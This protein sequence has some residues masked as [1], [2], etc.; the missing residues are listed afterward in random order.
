MQH[1]THGHVY[2]NHKEADRIIAQF[3][4]KPSAPVKG[5][6]RETLSQEKD[7]F[8]TLDRL[9]SRKQEPQRGRERSR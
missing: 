4:N 5:K 6:I 7:R 8:I 3:G 9:R 1:H 2:R